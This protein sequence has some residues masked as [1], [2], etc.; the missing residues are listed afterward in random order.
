MVF[1]AENN[2]IGYTQKSWFRYVGNRRTIRPVNL[3]IADKY[4]VKYR[5]KFIGALLLNLVVL[6]GILII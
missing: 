1:L 5:I 6:Y 3:K 4:T 2:Y